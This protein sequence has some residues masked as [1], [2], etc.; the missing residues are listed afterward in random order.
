MKR[1][2]VELSFSANANW[3]GS[4]LFERGATKLDESK[5]TE[6]IREVEFFKYFLLNE[7]P[8]A[9]TI[10]NI[11]TMNGITTENW[12]NWEWVTG[13]TS[14]TS[15][16]KLK[17]NSFRENGL[18]L[19][20][21]LRSYMYWFE[22]ECWENP[23]SNCWI[24]ELVLKILFCKFVNKERMLKLWNILSKIERVL[25]SKNSF[26]RIVFLSMFCFTKI[27]SFWE[28]LSEVIEILSSSITVKCFFE[29]FLD[30][31][32]SNSVIVSEDD[33]M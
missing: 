8:S 26:S 10:E 24:W 6:N 33:A 14:S 30:N 21:K 27:N 18:R 17:N 15:I 20:S 13:K 22:T 3:N 2:D 31:D 28:S 9:L 23:N 29:T 12:I 1:S 25:N 32:R 19:D 7:K 5:N 4:K 16:P 11:A